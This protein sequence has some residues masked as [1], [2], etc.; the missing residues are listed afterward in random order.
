VTPTPRVSLVLAAIAI[1]ALVLPLGLVALAVAALLAATLLDAWSVRAAPVIARRI[2]PV[3]SRGVP[4]ELHLEASAPAARRLLIHQPAPPE[5]RL[6]RSDGDGSFATELTASVRGLHVL[7]PVATRAVG[8]LGLGAW[9]RRVGDELHT[10]VYPDLVRARRLALA[11][12][13]GRLSEPGARVR[14]PIGVGTEF[15]SV[16][17]W[18]PDDD[19]RHINWAATTRIGRPMTNQYRLEQ[20]R[21]VKLLVDAGRLMA[22]AV[23]DR[24]RLDVALD[25]VAA[26]ALAADE[27]GDRCGTIAFD[28]RIRAELRPQRAGGR[29]VVQAL[30]DLQPRIVDCDYERAFVLANQGKRALVL[31]ATDLFDEGAARGLTAAIGPLARRHAVVVAAASDPEIDALIHRVAESARDVLEAA[32]AV[33]L[34]DSRE[35]AA[36]RLRSTG[37]RVVQAAPELLPGACVR[38]YVRAKSMLEV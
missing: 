5:L 21:D 28:D 36:A 4:V 1:S 9:H 12:R 30:F 27:L 19:V 3:L 34:L 16:R 23:G 29:E 2:A 10:R 26:V 37:A 11:A 6:E 20:A 32:A 7:P 17:E 15:E 35:R 22:A 38:A 14:G 13:E 25:A 24:S 18:L 8:R 33:D 31:V